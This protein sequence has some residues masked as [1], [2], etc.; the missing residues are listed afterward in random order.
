MTIHQH[1]AILTVFVESSVTAVCVGQ[2]CEQVTPS[3]PSIVVVMPTFLTGVSLDIRNHLR[4]EIRRFLWL[5]WNLHNN[6]CVDE[7]TSTREGDHVRNL[8]IVERDAKAAWNVRRQRRVQ[9]RRFDAKPKLL[10]GNSRAYSLEGVTRANSSSQERRLSE[11]EELDDYV[12]V[13]K[14]RQGKEILRY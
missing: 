5:N 11:V 9:V 1:A 10:T 14:D 4:G 12:L 3:G 2:T 8:Y 13:F 6:A 7:H